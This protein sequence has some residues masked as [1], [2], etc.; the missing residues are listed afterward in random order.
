MFLGLLFIVLFSFCF[1]TDPSS[2]R[3]IPT[4]YECQN[5]GILRNGKCEC[6][7][8]FFGRNCQRTM[9]CAGHKLKAD[10]TCVKCDDG[11]IGLYCDVI[12]CKN[13]KRIYGEICECEKPW[14][15][16]VCDQL[17]TSNVY[18]YYNRIITQFGPIGAIF[19]IP[20]IIV[21]YGCS[22]LAKK[23]QVKRVER[24]LEEQNKTD[25]SAAMV[26]DL[27]KQ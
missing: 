5:G 27:L 8:G 9:Q 4:K 24:A 7:A 20:M 19:I 25:V 18:L 17:V 6:P 14:S 10:G 15:G 16:K 21:R 11:Y 2:S 13:G 1:C 26:A 23:R 12:Q 22:K 3:E